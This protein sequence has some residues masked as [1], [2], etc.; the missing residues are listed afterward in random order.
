M[1][2]IIYT[3]DHDDALDIRKANREAHLKFLASKSLVKVMSAGPYMDEQAETMIGS[4]LIVEAD[5]IDVVREW[6]KNDPYVIAGLSKSV[7][8]H[9]FI[10][11]IGSP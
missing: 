5:T 11:A 4:L 9:P 2:F 3:Q 7:I 1:K 6:L 8:V 10:W